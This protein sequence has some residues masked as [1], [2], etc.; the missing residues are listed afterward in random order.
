MLSRPCKG[1]LDLSK[2]LRS[3]CFQSQSLSLDLAHVGLGV[4]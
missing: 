3:V 4:C 1:S 2:E